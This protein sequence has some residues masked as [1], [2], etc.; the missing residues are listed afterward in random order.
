MQKIIR[1]H[2]HIL[3]S[4]L[5]LNDI[6]PGLAHPVSVYD[7]SGGKTLLL[8]MTTCQFCKSESADPGSACEP[9][10]LISPDR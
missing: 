6:V 3:V 7:A 9:M 10:S 2:I 5:F 1:A 4:F 8:I